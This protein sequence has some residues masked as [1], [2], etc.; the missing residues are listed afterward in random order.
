MD[1]L[2]LEQLQTRL[3]GRVCEEPGVL[4]RIQSAP[5]KSAM[6]LIERPLGY[7][8]P[9]LNPSDVRLRPKRLAEGV[10]ALIASPPPR[11]NSGCIVGE[12]GVLVID[13]GINGAMARQ[14]QHCVRS[15]SD[16][17]ILYLANT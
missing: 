9:N 1:V 12:K 15:L 2:L 4:T 17:P 7:V 11:D 10:Y 5:E 6:E 8:G 3:C 16:K 13:A 14:I